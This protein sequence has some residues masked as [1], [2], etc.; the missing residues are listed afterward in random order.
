MGVPALSPD[1]RADEAVLAVPRAIWSLVPE[2]LIR[3]RVV[4]PVGLE[5]QLPGAWLLVAT[6]VPSDLAMADEIAFATGLR[7]KLVEASMASIRRLIALHLGGGGRTAGPA[8][9]PDRF[10][11]IELPEEDGQPLR[12]DEWVVPLAP[13]ETKWR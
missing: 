5:G 13:G 11:P 7:V 1:E 9:A 4:F 8:R 2:R 6:S 12:R 10:A 3:D